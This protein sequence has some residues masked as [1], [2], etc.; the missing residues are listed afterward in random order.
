MRARGQRH[1]PSF[2]WQGTLLIL[3]VVVL[4]VLGGLFLR[5]DRRLA[6]KEARERAQSSAEELAR[7][8]LAALTDFSWLE[9]TAAFTLERLRAGENR[10]V[11]FL[12]A[13]GRLAFPR[14]YAA[15]PAPPVLDLSALTPPQAR[16]WE[17]AR[18]GAFAQGDNGGGID[19]WERFL[20]ASPP[21]P[22]AA[23]GQFS[24]AVAYERQ[25][26][27][28]APAAFDRVSA[29][30]P[31]AVGE[32]GLPLQP[33]AEW[34]RLLLLKSNPA[35]KATNNL[36][37]WGQLLDPFCGDLITHPSPATA[38]LLDLAAESFAGLAA[39]PGPKAWREVWWNHE[40]T[41]ALFR[42]AEAARPPPARESA[43]T[44]PALFWTTLDAPWLGAQF[45]TN[46]C[47]VWQTWDEA[48]RKVSTE[49]GRA[50]TIPE[51]CAVTVTVS[52]TNLGT[53]SLSPA[54][55]RDYPILATAYA[56]DPAGPLKV[57][58]RLTDPDR[59]YARQRA[60]TL[61]F[62]ALIAVAAVGA[63]VGLVATGRALQ[64]QQR[65]LELKSNFVSSVT[66]EL[67]APLASVRLLA[68][69]LERG[70]ITL[71]EKR[72]EYFH[73]I[74]QECRRLSSLIEN[75]LD[76][77]RIEQGRKQYRLEPVD[78][79]DLARQTVQ[80]LEPYAAERQV[81]L[82]M[83]VESAKAAEFA[84][85]CDGQAIQQALINLVDNA[86]K[87][88]PPEAIVTIGLDSSDRTH[89]LWV[90]DHGPGIP[91]EDC[92]R[93][94]EQF[95]RRGSELRRE[96]AGIGIG[97]TLVKHIAEAHRGR[98]QVRSEVGKGSRFT[99]VL[100]MDT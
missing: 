15:A 73:F 17:A 83:R 12:D 2:L 90:E 8:C 47:I 85:R 65:L 71:P 21:P 77:A 95:Y 86:V 62:I 91:P 88:S 32:S 43:S 54:N 46:P 7:H 50:R 30:G 64:R 5:Q 48:N 18:T 28:E 52:G 3:P 69:S 79:A 96:S 9:P 89:R 42:Q 1:S 20:R 44:K 63:L 68:E 27:L 80:V 51:F 40:L 59:L 13:E 24:L 35:T 11:A 56:P 49:I 36:I 98:V 53:G 76:F 25:G 33:L 23:I 4:G 84:P 66:H 67:R 82:E 92:E 99:L 14:P 97:L 10:C 61:W 93:I 39:S 16:L 38:T 55:D 78:L 75:V 22:F 31:E 74:V 72:Q 57:T 70:K 94:F 29:L 45:V 60:R 19:A 100:P 58:L 87:H 37:A 26:R 6:D 34:H 41:R 81:H